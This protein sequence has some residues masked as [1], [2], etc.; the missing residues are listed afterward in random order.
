VILF[1]GF[2]LGSIEN[3]ED[4]QAVREVILERLVKLDLVKNIAE[5]PSMG[6]ELREIIEKENLA[7]MLYICQCSEDPY[8]NEMG[9]IMEGYQSIDEYLHRIDLKEKFYEII[10][11]SPEEDPSFKE[12]M[13][14]V[15][16][17]Y[18]RQRDEVT[19][20]LV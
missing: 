1:F 20:G 7:K 3:P 14:E 19:K 5:T 12:E 6:N 18:I 9:Q 16:R 13:K 2:G 15:I 8:L 10:E 4:K 17:E 11:E